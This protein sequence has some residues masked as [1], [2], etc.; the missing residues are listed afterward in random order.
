M[1]TPTILVASDNTTDAAL[2]KKLLVV[3][4][5]GLT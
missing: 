4:P 3:D 1:S 2:V 5:V